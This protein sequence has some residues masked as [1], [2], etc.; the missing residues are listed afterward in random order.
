[1]IDYSQ[2]D[3]RTTRTQLMILYKYMTLESAR[4]A[5][6]E[7]TLIFSLPLTF[8]D[9]FEL[10][11]IETLK[12]SNSKPKRSLLKQLFETNIGILCLTRTPLNPLMWAHYA[13]D[14]KGVVI[15]I[16]VDKA[17]FN[18]V[19]SNM[20][21][22]NF[23]HMLY[24]KTRPNIHPNVDYLAQSK[25]LTSCKFQKDIYELLQSY[26]LNKSSDW[27]YEEEIRVVK[28]VLGISTENTKNDS[29][30]FKIIKRKNNEILRAYQ[31]PDNAIKEVY[32]GAKCELQSNHLIMTVTD[33]EGNN[34]LFPVDDGIETFNCQL[35]KETWELTTGKPRPTPKER[36]EKLANYAKLI[37]DEQEHSAAHV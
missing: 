1:M 6:Q 18:N 10:A 32:F 14:H 31:L 29:G 8:N 17:G 3:K 26:F 16:D 36:K 24:T 7:N 4:I 12:S 21:P 33:E 2:Q 37:S 28:N 13:E 19:D 11:Q 25:L 22:A 5:L 15:G 27:H 9:P 20:I 23:G 30:Q 34:I 35:S